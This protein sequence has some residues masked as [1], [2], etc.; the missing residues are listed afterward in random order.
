M[1]RY[2]AALAG[3]FDAARGRTK[4]EEQC[5]RCH[6]L[7]GQG[8]KIGPDLAGTKGRAEETL[9][10]DILQP[11][12]QLTAGYRSYTVVTKNGDIFTGLLSAE[13]ATSITLPGEDGGEQTI[14]RQDLESL[15][16]SDV[17]LMPENFAE[18]LEPR[19]VA[20]LLAYL[21]QALAAAPDTSLTLF[22]DDPA[23][24]DA[25]VE[26]AGTATVT[27]TDRFTGTAALHVTPLQRYSGS[28]PGWEYRIVE[29]PGPG[30]FR[31]LRFAWKAPAAEGVML[32][33]AAAGQWPQ[34]GQPARRYFAGRNTTGWQA[35]QL[36]SAVP[37]EWTVVTVDLW[38]DAGEFT[39]TG[40]AP[41]AM[42][43]PAWFDHLELLRV[44]APDPRVPAASSSQ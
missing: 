28:I 23:F 10:V 43:G 37:R 3:P 36:A 17:S 7:L 9:L 29:Q 19:D 31:F 22:E 33:L 44:P 40:L 42:G 32:E 6:S 2:R 12:D 39:L 1:A 30:E 25:L 21:R 38:Q 13:T 18:L 35:R 5:I 20:D 11:S 24:A 41:T 15:Q 16:M 14:L 8:G 27:N 4:F 34:A 26:G